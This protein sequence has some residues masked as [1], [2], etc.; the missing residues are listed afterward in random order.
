MLDFLDENMWVALSALVFVVLVWRKAYRAVAD[1]LDKRSAD[2]KKNLDEAKAL[3]DEALSELS[4]C[5]RLQR[6][7]SQEAQEIL[8]HAK[9][10]AQEIEQTAEANAKRLI[11]R[12]QAQAN[13]KIA[14]L[15]A[16]ALREIR[17]HTA[18]LTS[19][20]TAELIA[21]K[22]DSKSATALI[23]SDLASIAA[24]KNTQPR[25]PA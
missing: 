16:Q 1:M 10:A 3:R 18:R 8:A 21:R 6:T 24:L 7:A 15:E 19:Q 13:A 23:K 20:A 12:R 25:P 14:T 2:I 5:R 11:A 9:K 22:L 17:A 4:K